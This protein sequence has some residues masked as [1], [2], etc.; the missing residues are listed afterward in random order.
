MPVPFARRPQSGPQ[1]LERHAENTAFRAE[2]LVTAGDL[3]RCGS[4]VGQ[5]DPARGARVRASAPK[6]KALWH[7]GCDSVALAAALP[8]AWRRRHPARMTKLASPITDQTPIEVDAKVACREAVRSV[9]IIMGRQKPAETRASDTLLLP[10][11]G[12]E[13]APERG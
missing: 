13:P 8:A 7:G 1:G 9:R 12:F 10:R 3:G 2:V 5:A 6:A 4:A 11:P